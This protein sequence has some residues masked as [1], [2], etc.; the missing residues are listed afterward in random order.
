[1]QVDWGSRDAKF[2]SAVKA[3]RHKMLQVGNV[4]GA[5]SGY[6]MIPMQGSG[7]M[8]IEAI[9]GSTVPPNGKVLI[10]KNGA[11]GDR[12]Q[13][14][15]RRLGIATVFLEFP[16]SQTPDLTAVEAAMVRHPEI[17]TVAVVHCE[18]TTGILNPIDKI[19]ELRRRHLPDAVY[20]VDAMSSFGGVPVDVAGLQ[21]DYLCTSSNKCVQGVPG[22]S[23][24]IANVHHLKQTEGWARS[25]C[26]DLL[27]Q[28]SGLERSGQF[29][30]TPPIQS[31]MA[32]K[33]A[34]DEIEQE[35][36]AEGR[37]RRYQANARVIVDGL[38][39][40]GFQTYLP[41]DDSFGWIIL[42][43]LAPTHPKWNFERFYTLLND[44]GFVIY[45]GKL[46][47]QDCFRIGCIGDLHPQDAQ[48][49]VECVAATL[50]QMGI[51]L[52]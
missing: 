2:I 9:L 43:F 7:S 27:A 41:E 35:G 40:L 24:I 52:K 38:K 39:G 48:A 11:Y 3:M 8:G 23:V 15:C 17:T 1:M 21:I 4:H 32:F 42:T 29:N 37:S 51:A 20:F 18:T 28:Y 46:T 10:I 47:E 30:N 44:E 22:F 49:L 33:Q 36:W 26:L 14:I 5:D 50:D 6:T 19:S 25:L 12:M 13:K 16:E 31:I 34:L 45:P